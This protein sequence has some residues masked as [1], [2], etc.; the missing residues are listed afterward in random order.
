MSSSLRIAV[1][2]CDTPV[3]KVNERYDGYGGMF[4]GF[5]KSSAE[6]LNQKDRLDPETGF[7]LTNFDVVN[8]N[9]YPKLDDI[10]AV[11]L[12]GSSVFPTHDFRTCTDTVIEHNSY[13][14]DQW[15]LDLIKFTKQVLAQDRVRLLG[16]CFGH[17]IVGRILG[18]K[19]GPSDEGWETSVCDMNLTETGKELFG[20]D[21]LVRFLHPF[22]VT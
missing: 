6:A 10:D 3:P 20:R 5:L 12:T 16:I 13:G 1:L 14:D 8:E 4:K 22:C 15:I 21:K 2:L 9:R 17:Q 18:S 7:E 19:V 11:I